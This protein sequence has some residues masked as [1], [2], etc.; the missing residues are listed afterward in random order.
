MQWNLLDGIIFFAFI[1][2]KRHCFRLY[3]QPTDPY[4]KRESTVSETTT[5]TVIGTNS[6]TAFLDKSS[7]IIAEEWNFRYFSNLYILNILTFTFA[8]PRLKM[9]S[10]LKI[11]VTA[12]RCHWRLSNRLCWK[13]P[14]VSFKNK[15]I[16]LEYKIKI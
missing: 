11:Q 1:N 14:L 15:L 4:R 6:T 2:L 12:Y 8:K 9:S 13:K 3:C 10:H 5:T 16:Y 7:K